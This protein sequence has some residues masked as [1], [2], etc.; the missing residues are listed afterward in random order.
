MEKEINQLIQE[1]VSFFSDNCYTQH[2]IDKYKSLWKYGIL[3]YM[4]DKNIS[5]YNHY[6]QLIMYYEIHRFKEEGFSIRRIAKHLKMDFRTVRKYLGMHQEDFERFLDSKSERH[7]LLGPYEQFILDRLKL[8]PET[9]KQ[10]SE[11]Q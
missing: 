10:H 7:R 4:K 2:R 9:C 11:V 3:R 8:Y 5:L 6:N 1:C